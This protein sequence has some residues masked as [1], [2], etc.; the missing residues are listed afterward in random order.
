[1]K[2]AAR[3]GHLAIVKFLV[4]EARVRRMRVCDG[5]MWDS[6][7]L[8]AYL[9]V[10]GRH[11]GAAGHLEVEQYLFRQRTWRH[12]GWA[13]DSHRHSLFPWP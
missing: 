9:V 1:M 5:A 11:A 7:G 4:E 8:D 12:D 10:V 2:A 3:E 6:R 13:A